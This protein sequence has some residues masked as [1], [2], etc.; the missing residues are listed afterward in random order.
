MRAAALE[1]SDGGDVGLQ[2]LGHHLRA[3]RG[4]GR[5]QSL[6]G[7]IREGGEMAVDYP[8]SCSGRPCE[9]VEASRRPGLGSWGGRRTWTCANR[10][11]AGLA[12]RLSGGPPLKFREPRVNLVRSGP[13]GELVRRNASGGP[14]RTV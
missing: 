12:S 5:D 10:A 6:T 2:H 7:M 11:G 9:A 1:A 3:D 4:R 13:S 8:A 14:E